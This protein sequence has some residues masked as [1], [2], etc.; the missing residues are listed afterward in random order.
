MRKIFDNGIMEVFRLSADET[1]KSCFIQHATQFEDARA[2][3][4]FAL[5]Q[6]WGAMA[7]FADV[8]NQLNG[9]Q[10]KPAQRLSPQEL[11]M[12][13]CEVVDAGWSEMQHR[14][15]IVNV[16]SLKDKEES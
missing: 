2:A 11:V 9:E 10:T 16:E 5:I 8:M 14:G 1:A 3:R 4:A 6:H 15:W 7:V 13:V 12:R